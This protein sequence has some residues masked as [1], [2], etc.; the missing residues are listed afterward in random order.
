MLGVDVAVEAAENYRMPRA[1]G[2]TVRTAIDMIIGSFC[3]LNGQVLLH[4]DRDFD[5]VVKYLGLR[6]LVD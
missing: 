5:P 1:K 4:D 3:L 6:V 2:I